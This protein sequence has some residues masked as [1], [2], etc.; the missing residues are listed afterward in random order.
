MYTVADFMTLNP[1]CL[2][3]SNSLFKGRTTMKKY[4]IRHIPIT[5][6]DSGEFAG[7]LTQK[8]VLSNAIK[9]INTQGLEHLEDAEKAIA[10]DQVMDTD[11]VT[12]EK[13]TPLLEA[14]RFFQENRHGCIAVLENDKVVGILTSSDFV[15]FAITELEKNN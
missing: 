4:R 10:I 9:I 6:A 15:K 1:I 3:T 14:A 7:I 5:H 12:V 13:N 8:V 11:V 2:K